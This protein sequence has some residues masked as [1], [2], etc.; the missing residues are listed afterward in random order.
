MPQSVSQ[1][2]LVAHI[3]SGLLWA[4]CRELP[5][6]SP[7]VSSAEVLSFCPNVVSLSSHSQ[8]ALRVL[9]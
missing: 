9:E 3:P 1:K 5:S 7:T 4:V 2:L 6:T 8:V